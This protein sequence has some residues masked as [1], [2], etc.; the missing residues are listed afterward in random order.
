MSKIAPSWMGIT[1]LSLSLLPPA[2]RFIPQPCP[3]GMSPLSA[4]CQWH[5]GWPC[6]PSRS[7][8]GCEAEERPELPL[9]WQGVGVPGWLELPFKGCQLHVPCTAPPGMRGEERC[10]SKGSLSPCTALWVPGGPPRS[11]P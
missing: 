10:G 7:W 11:C 9:P 3:Q 2:Q 5:T 8:A 4:G 6:P 1:E